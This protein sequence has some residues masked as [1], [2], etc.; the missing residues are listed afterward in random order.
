VLSAI[1]YLRWRAA[2]IQDDQEDITLYMTLRQ[3]DAAEAA[4]DIRVFA[5][6]QGIDRR[7]AYRVSLCM[8]EM[9]AYI[10]QAETISSFAANME[11][12]VEVIE[13]TDQ[14]AGRNPEGES[15]S[16]LPGDSITVDITLRFKPSRQA[17][18][19]TLDEGTFIALDQNEAAQQLIT[20]NYG[21]IKKIAD[22]VEYQY[23]LN[24]NYTK[25][26]VNGS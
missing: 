14:F 17:I 23:L 15:F 12:Y 19:I 10:Q 8:E 26:V 5:E 3:E 6:E 21:L 20:D 22:S 16:L 1:R 24:M 13:R 25:I 11:K 4:H 7:S 9:T 2:D 18:L